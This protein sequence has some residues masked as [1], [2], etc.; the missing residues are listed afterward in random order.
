ML[1]LAC[2]I[3]IPISISL[4]IL[5]ICVLFYSRCEEKEKGLPSLE[6][7]VRRRLGGLNGGED[8]M[9]AL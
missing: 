3:C 8:V 5:T 2:L 6:E 4:L 9:L 1:S 7:M